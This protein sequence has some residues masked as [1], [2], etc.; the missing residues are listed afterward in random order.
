MDDWT[1]EFCAVARQAQTAAMANQH[2]TLYFIM[3]SPGALFGATLIRTR[4][5][6]CVAIQKVLW[7]GYERRVSD[8]PAGRFPRRRFR[9]LDI[10]EQG[11]GIM[12]L[13]DRDQ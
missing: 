1:L 9:S 4:F 7:K 10:M 13:P 11:P 3:N 6:H 8:R 2:A 12:R 5:S